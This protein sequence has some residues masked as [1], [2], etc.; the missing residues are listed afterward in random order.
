MWRAL[1]EANANPLEEITSTIQDTA[2]KLP[3]KTTVES[4]LT[5]KRYEAHQEIHSHKRESADTTNERIS[6]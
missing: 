2:E 6:S 4:K 1:L 5:V 3:W